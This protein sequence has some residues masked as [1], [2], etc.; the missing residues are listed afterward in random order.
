[1]WLAAAGV[2]DAAP[3]VSERELAR[4]LELREAT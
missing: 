3:A 1:M 4:A 2:V